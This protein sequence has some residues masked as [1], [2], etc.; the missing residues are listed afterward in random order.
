MIL[1]I[2]PSEKFI[3]SFIELVDKEFDIGKHHFWLSGN[4]D[5]YKHRSREQVYLAKSSVLGKLKGLLNLLIKSNAADKIILHGIFDTSVLVFLFCNPRFYKKCYWVIWGGD[6]YAY[7][8]RNSS[9]KWY[10]K[11]IFRKRVIKKI[12]NLV[13]YIEGDAELAKKWYGA[14][15]HIHQCLMYE[16]NVY[17]EFH[18]KEKKE[19]SINIQVGN[20]ADPANNHFEVFDDI[21]KFRSAN[22]KIF[23]PLSYGDKKY[24]DMVIKK[25]YELFGE[26]FFPLTTFMSFQ[27]YIQFLGDID[28]AIF[29][30]RRQ[31]AMG[32]TISLLGLGKKVFIR[33]DVPQYKLFIDMGVSVSSVKNLEIVPLAIDV[34]EKNKLIIAS[35]FSRDKLVSQ[36]KEIFNR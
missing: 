34:R 10:V 5:D 32:N 17:H 7:N 35:F 13:T 25:G 4:H 30:H 26:N 18:I 27:D 29:S 22:V 31:Q 19:K 8:Y 36:W 28:I 33:D 6:L 12:G 11:E 1:H 24:A 15:G 16:S 2:A 9:L 3:P 23:V 21:I 20:S 14:E